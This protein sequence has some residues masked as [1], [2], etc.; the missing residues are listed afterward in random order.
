MGRNGELDGALSRVFI[1]PNEHDSNGEAA[2]MVDGLFAVARA[3]SYGARHLGGGDSTDHRGAM[4]VFSDTVENSARAIAGR[5]GDVADAMNDVAGVLNRL[6]D[7]E[8]QRQV[9][10]KGNHHGGR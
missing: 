9:E 8:Y 1:S 5:I 7:L 4:E 3:I 10:V 6:A 2:N